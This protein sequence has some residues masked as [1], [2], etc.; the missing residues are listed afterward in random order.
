MCKIASLKCNT[1]Y[2]ITKL[3]L[4]HDKRN[5]NSHQLPYAVAIETVMTHT[6]FQLTDFSVTNTQQSHMQQFIYFSLLFTIQ[7]CFMTSGN[8]RRSL[9]H[10]RS[11]LLIRSFAPSGTHLGKCRSTFCIREYV[12]LVSVDSNGGLPTR[13]S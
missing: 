2:H 7:G 5:L 9:G 3:E 4:R 12:L 11:N 10:R 8:G 6:S 13:N 1:V